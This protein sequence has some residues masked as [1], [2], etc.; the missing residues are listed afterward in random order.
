ME[1]ELLK[2]VKDSM[3]IKHNAL[4]DD[5]SDDIE[6]AIADMVRVGINPYSNTKKR[7]LKPDRLVNKAIELYCKG[8][9][10]YKGKGQQ[11]EA[12]YEKVRDAMSLCGDYNE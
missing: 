8:Q 9:A 10:D 11:Y 6:T 4:D 1:N 5:I 7:T 12:S 3:R 2:A